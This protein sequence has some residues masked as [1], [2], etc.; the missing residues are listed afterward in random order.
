MHLSQ[1]PSHILHPSIHPSTPLCQCQVLWGSRRTDHSSATH[2][3]LPGLLP[4]PDVAPEAFTALTAAQRWV[5]AS[6]E[7]PNLET[8]HICINLTIKDLSQSALKEEG[9]SCVAAAG[10]SHHWIWRYYASTIYKAK[11][12][13][14]HCS[15]SWATKQS[16]S[17]WF[18]TEIIRKHQ[19][20]GSL[21]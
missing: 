15:C 19:T 4:L 11:Q 3:T 12:S 10:G 20:Y 8:R 21:K 6:P 16:Q 2:N 5:T 13:Q 17:R 18:H 7:A 9:C 1:F 14:V